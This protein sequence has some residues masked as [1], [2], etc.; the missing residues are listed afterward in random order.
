[1]Y[2][3]NMFLE[4]FSCCT[5]S[6][7]GFIFC[8]VPIPHIFGCNFHTTAFRKRQKFCI[9]FRIFFSRFIVIGMNDAK[10]AACLCGTFNGALQVG[11]NSRYADR[12]RGMGLITNNSVVQT[13]SL[14]LSRKCKI[15]WTIKF[16]G[17]EC[18]CLP[19]DSV[20]IKHGKIPSIKTGPAAKFNRLFHAD[21]FCYRSYFC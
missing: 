18:F 3:I 20:H 13:Y 10:L 16:M 6:K 11:V 14:E 9:H 2:N 1:M 15:I 5:S 7:R 17:Y 19:I 4:I 8:A 12:E 21:Y